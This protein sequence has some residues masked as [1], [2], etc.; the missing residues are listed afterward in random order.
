[1]SKTAFTYFKKITKKVQRNKFY[2]KNR[3]TPIAVQPNGQE[4]NRCINQKKIYLTRPMEKNK[5]LKK[6]HSS[7]VS[8]WKYSKKQFDYPAAHRSQKQRETLRQKIGLYK[9]LRVTS[10]K[11]LRKKK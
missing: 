3:K 4:R 7:D 11:I 8:R 6:P 9:A 10:Q 5:P 1:M 2:Q